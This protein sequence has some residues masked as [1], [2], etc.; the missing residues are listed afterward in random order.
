MHIAEVKGCSLNSNKT[1]V[2]VFCLL[3][4]NLF[5]CILAMCFPN[6]A[7]QFPQSG[8]L[9]GEMKWRWKLAWKCR[10]SKY[11]HQQASLGCS[12]NIYTED[13]LFLLQNQICA[14]HGTALLVH[15]LSTWSWKR[16]PCD[17][18]HTSATYSGL[19]YVTDTGTW[20]QNGSTCGGV[21]CNFLNISFNKQHQK[22][23]EKL[24]C[25]YFSF[26]SYQYH[27]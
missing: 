11:F 27:H 13:V 14:P 12:I 5:V 15:C 6:K 9:K 20:E 10:N 23:S 19:I 18:F 16:S 22:S 1:S 2:W 7:L 26:H 17:T 24:L 3:A 8:C 4:D 21:F 25:V